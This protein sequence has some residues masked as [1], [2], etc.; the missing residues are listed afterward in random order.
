MD[1]TPACSDLGSA[2]SRKGPPV[3]L[4]MHLMRFDRYCAHTRV[5]STGLPTPLA[6][7]IFAVCSRRA[8]EKVP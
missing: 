8:D 6:C 5:V 7:N 2:Y 4:S 3:S 1:V